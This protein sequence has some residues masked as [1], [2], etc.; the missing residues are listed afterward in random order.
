MQ[1][2][3][4]PQGYLLR[5]SKGEKLAE[6]LT[7]FCTEK[8]ITSG[9]FQAIGALS[10]AELGYYNLEKKEYVWKTMEGDRELVSLTGNVSLVDNNPFV[11]MHTVLSDENFSCIGGHLKE[12]IVGATCEVNII[13]LQKEIHREF[14]EEVGLKLLHCEENILDTES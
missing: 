9:F 1:Y 7:A 2:T 4:T 12:G 8:H 14:D 6:R 3:K 5:L 10:H 11:H 13:D